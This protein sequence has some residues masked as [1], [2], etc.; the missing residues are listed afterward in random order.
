M[1]ELRTFYVCAYFS[2]RMLS[3]LRIF[4][5]SPF[6]D[7]DIWVEN[8]LENTCTQKFY[9]GGVRLYGCSRQLSPN[10]FFKVPQMICT[11]EDVRHPPYKTQIAP[12]LLREDGVGMKCRRDRLTQPPYDV[13]SVL[14]LPLQSIPILEPEVIGPVYR[15][16]SNIVIYPD[17][18]QCKYIQLY[19]VGIDQIHR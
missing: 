12:R 5:T 14:D 16:I 13:T 1:G 3:R 6:S 10:C 2:L 11:G 9:D 8:F 7:S 17:T 4:S 18:M 19:E 15:F